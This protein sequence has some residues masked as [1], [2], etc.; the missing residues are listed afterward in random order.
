MWQG[1]GDIINAF[2][3]KL[4]LRALSLTIGPLLLHRLQIPHTYCWSEALLPKPRDWRDN[5]GEC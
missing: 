5:I 4:G 3:I 1:L 2:R